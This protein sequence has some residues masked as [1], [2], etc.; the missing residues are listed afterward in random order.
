[1]RV[2][3]PAVLVLAIG[4]VPADAQPGAKTGR[5]ITV[6][7]KATVYAK[8]DMAHIYYGVKASEPSAEAVKDVL[9]KNTKAISDAALKLKLTG[10]TI[11]T[12][13]MAI[14]LSSGN[15]PG[16][17]VPPG[18]RRRRLAEALGHLSA[19]HRKPLRS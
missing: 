3:L 1:M 9:T 19:I 10:L 15:N 12:A 14:K 4:S 11:T 8:P 5:V 17:A 6:I 16:L 2:L 13:P 7:G 18:A